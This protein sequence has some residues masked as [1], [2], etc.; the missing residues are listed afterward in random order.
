MRTDLAAQDDGHA[1]QDGESGEQVEE[2]RHL[3]RELALVRRGEH[4]KKQQKKEV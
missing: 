4:L 2:E 3:G 1:H